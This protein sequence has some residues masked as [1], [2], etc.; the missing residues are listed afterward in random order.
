MN[1]YISKPIQVEELI[2]ALLKI[3]PLSEK[4]SQVGLE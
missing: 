1:D 2:E 3:T 4:H